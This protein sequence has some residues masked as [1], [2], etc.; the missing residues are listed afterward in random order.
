MVFVLYDA[1]EARMGELI[2]EFYVVHVLVRRRT[3][4]ICRVIGPFTEVAKAWE[5]SSKVISTGRVREEKWGE[6][7]VEFEGTYVQHISLLGERP[8]YLRFDASP[9]EYKGT[10]EG[11]FDS[12]ECFFEYASIFKN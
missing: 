4:K 11:V 2:V 6:H 7:G 1:T 5:W 12:I 10:P 3:H 9:S 8:N